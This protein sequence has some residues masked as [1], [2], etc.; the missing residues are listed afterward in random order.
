V[1]PQEIFCKVSR[2][3][4]EL[5]DKYPSTLGCLSKT[6]GGVNASL[7]KFFHKKRAHVPRSKPQTKAL[8]RK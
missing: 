5:S 4:G 3:G 1:R 8:E 2:A 6:G 7:I